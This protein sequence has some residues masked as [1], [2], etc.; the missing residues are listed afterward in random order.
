MT[1]ERHAKFI[2][3]LLK[4][5]QKINLTAITDPDEI[6]IKHIEDSLAPLHYIKGATTLLDLGS[7]AGFPG[8]PLKIARPDLRVVLVEA[9]R[10][11]VGF[12]NHAIAELKLTDIVAVHAR[13]EVVGA[14][15]EPPLRQPFDVVVSRATWEL[16]SFIPLALPYLA[17]SGTIIAMKGAKWKEELASA[18]EVL[19]HAQLTASSHPYHLSN[20]D[21]RALIQI[22][23]STFDRE[24]RR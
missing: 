22:F 20:G 13:A 17:P 1:N 12:L 8:I 9:T 15:R 10:K 18:K 5:N 4:W 7:G 16:E 3:L 6:R 14:V 2:H 19:A 24:G 21:E 11:K 23:S